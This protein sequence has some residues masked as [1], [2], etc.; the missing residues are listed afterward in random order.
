MEE[1]KKEFQEIHEMLG[2]RV[3]LLISGAA[4][5]NREVE[6]GY[7]DFGINLV[8]GYGLTET[9]PVIGIGTKQ[10]YKL[11]SIGKCVPSV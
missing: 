1:K 4:S 3:R 8:Q 5:L 2:G 11:G 10:N 7:R 6:Q 9:S